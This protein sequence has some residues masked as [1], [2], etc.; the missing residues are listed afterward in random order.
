MV[1][2]HSMLHNHRGLF[3]YY[4]KDTKVSHSKIQADLYLWQRK[5][6]TPWI[7]SCEKYPRRYQP[8]LKKALQKSL[9]G[10][11]LL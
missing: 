4:K 6:E 11:G 5:D 3:G 10:M 9:T 7:L 8:F 1:I 2:R